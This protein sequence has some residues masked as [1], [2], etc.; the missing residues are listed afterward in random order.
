M[1][2]EPFFASVTTYHYFSYHYHVAYSNKKSNK[3]L[4][5][6][7]VWRAIVVSMTE[8]AVILFYINLHNQQT[9]AVT[10]A[11]AP[12]SAEFYCGV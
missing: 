9:S 5:Y 7:H 8:K 12:T 1:K 2:I 10:L 6:S 3:L 4:L 11:L